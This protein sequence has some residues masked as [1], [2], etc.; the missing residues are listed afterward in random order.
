MQ[1][2]AKMQILA[3]KFSKGDL[4]R[5]VMWTIVLLV[6]VVLILALFYFSGLE[7]LREFVLSK[8]FG[9]G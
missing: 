4:D 3:G 6:I 8:I 1:N 7:I 9:K 2:G 5:K